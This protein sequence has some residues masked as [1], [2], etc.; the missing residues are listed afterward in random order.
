MQPVRELVAVHAWPQ[1]QWLAIQ[2]LRSAQAMAVI[3]IATPATENRTAA[4]S[5]VRSA[6]RETLALL[7]GQPAA[8]ITLVSPV[9][10]AIWVDSTPLQLRL[11]I[12]HSPGVSVAAICRGASVGTDVMRVEAA[13]YE[14]L[15]LMRLARD[16]LG[17][18]ATALLQC[19]PP[20]T[21]PSAFGQAWTG[22]EAALKCLGLALTEW[23]P[24]LAIQLARCRVF[25]LDLPADYCGSVAIAAHVLPPLTADSKRD[26]SYGTLGR[27]SVR[28]D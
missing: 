17:P 5:L 2:A 16:Y 3:R 13:T 12:S 8:S 9:G 28:P 4:R 18:Q 27:L 6:L 19:T 22:F 10:R 11:S 21:F 23:S 7:L 25:A 15:D 1:D 26:V 20:E 14:H 24:E